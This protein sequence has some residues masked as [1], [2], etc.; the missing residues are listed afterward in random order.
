MGIDSP[1]EPM[2]TDRRGI[3]FHAVW[4]LTSMSLGVGVFAI[5]FCFNVLGVLQGGILVV[6]LGFLANT[7]IERLLDC[8]EI[9][10]RSKYEEIANTAFGRGGQATMALV[11][12]ITTFIASLSYLA[13]S[14]ELLTCVV[15]AFLTGE[16][17]N[18]QGG[19]ASVL[20]KGKR[21]IVLLIL[22][23]I[24]MPKLLKR[25][26]GD[27]AL[28]STAGV[29]SMSTA[30]I[31]FVGK[32]LLV[33]GEGCEDCPKPP[34]LAGGN[35]QEILENMATLAFSFSM[36]FAVGPLVGDKVAEYGSVAAAAKSMR[37]VVRT[38]ISFSVCIY[39]LV[40]LT[41]ALA[42]G[43]DIRKLSLQ[44]L[45]LQ[46]ALPQFVSAVVGTCSLLLVA[47]VGF[48]CIE[49]VELFCKMANPN[50][51]S[52]P[53]IAIV[54]IVGLLCV[55]IDAFI[56]TRIAFALTGALGLSLGA[57]VMPALLYFRLRERGQGSIYRFGSALVLLC[58]GA[59]ILIGGTPATVMAAIHSSEG[60]KEKL[61]HA[62]YFL[63]GLRGIDQ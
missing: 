38:S 21:A 25:S 27:N 49:S 8:A 44:N 52:D 28:I 50:S 56:D 17:I 60:S 13:A 31:I 34:P 29:F 58:F 33:L 47:I 24:T 12:F 32:C 18:K 51:R 3:D 14:T 63:Q 19:S 20:T 2:V 42:Y 7:A 57:Y 1:E 37:P 35:L 6:V 53:R 5:P 22:V 48:P 40:G 4:Q 54:C 16:D 61:S 15:Y 46:G 41:G 10:S 62:G 45:S 59:V 43:N 26:M 36:V 9:H 23:M 11:I 30:A 39:L 55:G